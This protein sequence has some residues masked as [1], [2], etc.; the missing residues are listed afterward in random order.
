MARHGGY[1]LR[2]LT[3][4]STGY[5]AKRAIPTDGFTCHMVMVY[6]NDHVHYAISIAE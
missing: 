3:L 1:T 6:V 2:N 5:N 4:L